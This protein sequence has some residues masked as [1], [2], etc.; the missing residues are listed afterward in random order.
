MAVTRVEPDLKFVH[1]VINTGGDSLKKCFQCATCSVVCSISP[2]KRPFPRKE[3]IWAQWGLKDKLIASPDVWLCHQCNDCS[4]HC[5]RSA[6][7]GDVLAAVRKHSLIEYATPGFFARWVARAGFLP[8]LFIIPAVLL[9]LALAVK[10]PL[11]DL[12]LPAFNAFDQ[13]LGLK[14]HVSH[15]MEYA[16]LFPHWLLIGFFSSFTGLAMLFG[17]IGIV[18][19]WRDMHAADTRAGHITKTHGLISSAI[20]VI[21]NIMTHNKFSGCT[22]TK[23]RFISHLG[24]F[25]GFIGLLIVTVWAIVVLY[26]TQ[27]PYP[28]DFMNPMKLFGNLSGIALIAGCCIVIYNRL[29]N[30]DATGKST[31]FDWT[32]VWILMGV[33]ITGFITQFMR[34]AEVQAVG[35]PVY[36]IHLVFVFFLLVYLPYSKFAHVLY[37]TVAMIYAEHTG[38][39]DIVEPK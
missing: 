38:R 7:P 18:R 1:N 24:I 26:I 17:L 5:P 39:N 34:F 15:G 35:F 6:R 22:A 27:G 31:N 33:G 11:N 29:A 10:A 8:I 9:A 14:E 37:R 19:F 23:S 16:G 25:Y 12:L 20:K 21:L 28:F 36:F 30:K 4:T 32:F 3:M 2:D 13:A